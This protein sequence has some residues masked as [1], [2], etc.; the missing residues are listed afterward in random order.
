MARSAIIV[1]DVAEIGAVAGVAGN[2]NLAGT[3]HGTVMLTF[4]KDQDV[5]AA[6]C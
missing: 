3:Y 4:G 2:I 5:G 1:M 6:R